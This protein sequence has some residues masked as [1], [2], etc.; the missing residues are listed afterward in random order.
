MASAFHP[1]SPADPQD[2]SCSIWYIRERLA[3]RD[4]SVERMARY[5]NSLIADYGFPKPWPREKKGGG[6]TIEVS[7]KSRWPRLAVDQWLEDWLP[8]DA[9]A[10]AEAAARARA[11]AEMDGRACHLQLVK[12]GRRG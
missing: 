7:D 5:L 6:L 8:P 1:Q 9:A 10:A 11:A 2:H 3:R 4:Y 12:G